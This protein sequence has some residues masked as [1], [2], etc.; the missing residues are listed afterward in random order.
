MLKLTYVSQDKEI[1]FIFPF[2]SIFVLINTHGSKRNSS[3]HLQKDS[4]LLADHWFKWK[5]N[6]GS[7]ERIPDPTTFLNVA[8]KNIVSDKNYLAETLTLIGDKKK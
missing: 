5:H 6:I 1:E 4:P 7:T 8:M 2:L 3:N